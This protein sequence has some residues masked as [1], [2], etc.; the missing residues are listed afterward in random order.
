MLVKL[1]I[2]S[3]LVVLAFIG[4]GRL[5]SKVQNLIFCCI[6]VLAQPVF[7]RV[8]IFT[9]ECLVSAIATLFVTFPPR[10]ELRGVEI[11]LGAHIF[12]PSMHRL[13]IC[14]RRGDGKM[15]QCLRTMPELNWRSAGRLHGSNTE[16]EQNE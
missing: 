6:G 14:R 8:I 16:S 2:V 3:L 11:N 10:Q 13:W 12:K 5:A 9:C 4:F 7:P 15:Q 1:K